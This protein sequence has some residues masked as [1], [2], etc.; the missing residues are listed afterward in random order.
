M[1][2]SYRLVRLEPGTTTN[3]EARIVPPDSEILTILQDQKHLRDSQKRAESLPSSYM[4][5][6]GLAFRK[7]SPCASRGTNTN[8]SR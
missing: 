3:D 7:G 6:A 4:I 8:L 2:L 5:S 1:D